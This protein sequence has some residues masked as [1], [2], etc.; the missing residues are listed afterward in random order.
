MHAAFFAASRIL[1]PWHLF[2]ASASR[3]NTAASASAQNRVVVFISASRRDHRPPRKPVSM[4]KY[5]VSRRGG[6]PTAILLCSTGACGDRPQASARSTEP[7]IRSL[8][9]VSPPHPPSP[10]SRGSELERVEQLAQL[11]AVGVWYLVLVES[12]RP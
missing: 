12:V 8:A 1:A 5:A 11:V 6:L 9:I 7:R 3:V 4:E 2:C 10:P